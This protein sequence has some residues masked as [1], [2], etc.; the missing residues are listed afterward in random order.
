MDRNYVVGATIKSD[1][2]QLPKK[3]EKKKNLD[4][5]GH[6]GA[7]TMSCDTPQKMVYYTIDYIADR[8]RDEIDFV[9]WTGDNARHNGDRH[10]KRT[11][12]EVMAYNLKVT[13]AL[14]KAFTVNN[15]VIPIIPC[16]G[17]ND[18]QPRN[19]L[20]DIKAN[21]Q[22][23]AFSALWSDFIPSSQVSVFNRGGYF[24]VDPVPGLR[25]LSINSLFFFTANDVVHSCGDSKSPGYRHLTWMHAQ[26][27]KARK[28]HVKVIIIGHVPPTIK[29]FKDDCLED[30][31]EL[32]LKYNDIIT[33]HLYGHMN[34]DH[35]QILSAKLKKKK[36][37]KNKKK[38]K[39]KK[40]AIARNNDRFIGR[41][42]SQYHKVKK[43]RQKNELVVVHVVPS[44]YPVF[45]PTFRIN[46]YQGDPT[47]P[48]FGTWMQYTQYFSNLTHWNGQQRGSPEF[49]I[50]YTTNETYG[51]KNLTAQSWLDFAERLVNNTHKTLWKQYKSHM[52]VHTNKKWY[53]ESIPPVPVKKGW[54]EWL[55]EH[56]GFHSF[57][58]YFL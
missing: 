17:N 15:K 45:Y 55:L 54:W 24:A 11:R 36:K 4:L 10:L 1:C 33:S 42:Q 16:I 53:E 26:L 50:E 21:P 2:H 13:N 47:L 8:W 9:V 12:A 32:S 57:I 23:L 19:S 40:F 41:L 52:F 22:L 34:I 20:R 37:P 49:E 27:R 58:K 56:L 38:K 7:P 35:F 46:E 29:T 48:H 14:I 51:M 31:L 30:Y 28:Q 44:I 18:I 43:L 25:V 5:A 39:N 3:K 6:W